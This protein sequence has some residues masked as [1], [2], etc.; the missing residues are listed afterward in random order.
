M[1][2]E[3]LAVVVW[4]AA[5]TVC[6]IAFG[7]ACMRAYCAIRLYGTNIDVRRSTVVGLLMLLGIITSVFRLMQMR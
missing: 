2:S 5:L 3:T 4:I 1:S 6:S 7:A